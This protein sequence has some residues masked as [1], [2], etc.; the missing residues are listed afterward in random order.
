MKHAGDRS[1]RAGADIRGRARDRA[2]NRK[3]AE[4]CGRDVTDALGDQLAVG[5]VTATGHAVGDHRR[6]KRLDRSE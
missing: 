4:C 5:A 2:G 3:A 6:Q 1:A